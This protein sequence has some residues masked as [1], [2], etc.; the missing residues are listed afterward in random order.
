MSLELLIESSY[1]KEQ[2]EEKFKYVEFI[3]GYNSILQFKV[4]V[5]HNWSV[6]SVKPKEP[7]VENPISLIGRLTSPINSNFDISVWSAYLASEI[8]PSDWL[9]IWCNSQAYN[10]L[11]KRIV[12]SSYGNIAD[13]LAT[14]KFNNKNYLCRLFAIKDAERLY[15]L[16]SKVETVSAQE[17][18]LAQEISLIAIQTFSL[19]NPTKQKLAEKFE[20]K[21]FQTPEKINFVLPFNWIKE[22]INE[23]PDQGQG[24]VAKNRLNGEIVGSLFVVSSLINIKNLADI[25]EILIA[26]IYNNNFEPVKNSYELI[27]ESQ[28]EQSL[29][30]SIATRRALKNKNEYEILSARFHSS[31]SS[32]TFILLTPAKATNFEVWA[33]NRRAFELAFNY[34]DFKE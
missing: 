15:M 11:D 25:E 2:V 19:L 27:N 5:P 26:K 13:I 29:S 6:V 7:S 34:L 4:A 18:E 23:V 32:I 3:E 22:D 30:V 12:Q 17:F 33:V 21:S 8:H 9:E 16:V 31:K 28:P 10:V 1:T 14:K 24:I 20:I